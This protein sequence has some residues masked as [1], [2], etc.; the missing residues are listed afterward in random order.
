MKKY[1]VF[2]TL[3]CLFGC[4]EKA[5][6]KSIDD[7]VTESNKQVKEAKENLKKVRLSIIDK[8]FKDKKMNSLYKEFVSREDRGEVFDNYFQAGNDLKEINKFYKNGEVKRSAVEKASLKFKTAKNAFINEW[9]EF[10]K[11]RK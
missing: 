11:S 10:M 7:K 6:S 1:L 8:M 4:D 3:V 5:T 2:F 9:D